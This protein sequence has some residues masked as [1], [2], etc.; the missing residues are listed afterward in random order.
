MP[1]TPKTKPSSNSTKCKPKNPSG[2][3]SSGKKIPTDSKKNRLTETPKNP[4]KSYAAQSDASSVID[5]GGSIYGGLGSWAADSVYRGNTPRKAPPRE[6]SSA[7]AEE[8]A[9]K[10]AQKQA[11]AAAAA[12]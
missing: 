10:K 9:R 12:K 4:P 6:E 8:A 3:S 7:K 2:S 11:A 1:Q 5:N